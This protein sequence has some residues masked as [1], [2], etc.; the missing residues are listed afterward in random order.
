[1]RRT[2]RIALFAALAAALGFLLAPVPNVELVTFSLFVAGSALGPT[3]GAAASLIAIAL[4][5]GLNPYG[6]SLAFPLLFGAQ[7][8]AGLWIAALGAL[9]GQLWRGLPSAARD[10]WA[11]RALLLPFALA[12]A[13]ALPLLPALSFALLGGGAWQGWAALGLL[14]TAGSL[15]VNAL[16]F[17][18]S[19]GPLMRQVA[20]LDAA[21]RH[22]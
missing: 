16:I 8:V 19:Y 7:L 15:G 11:G 13:L 20:R 6:S 1:M 4:Y 18:S 2:V 3:G 17:L 10:G 5:Y 22:A 9:C 21:G 12:A 14:M